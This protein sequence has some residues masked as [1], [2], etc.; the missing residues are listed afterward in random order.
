MPLDDGR[1]VRVRGKADRV[2]RRANGDLVVIDYKTGSERT[3]KSLSHEAPVTAG[4]HLQLPVYAHAAR[5]A[6]GVPGTRVE[7]YYWFVGR[8]KNHRIGYVVDGPV[9]DVFAATVR[10]IVDG[11]EAGVFPARPAEP[12]RP[13]SS[14]AASA[15]P[16]AWAR[17]TVGGSGR[18]KFD[19]PELAG[20]LGLSLLEGGNA[21]PSGDGGE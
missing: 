9:D 6:F 2:D 11:I 7:A 21:A 19:A 1:V 16:T 10:T 5:A 18:R 13:R 3:Y 4:T 14:S 8:G 17:P 15:I 12:G 20:F